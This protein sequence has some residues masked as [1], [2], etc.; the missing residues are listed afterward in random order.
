MLLII[1][2]IIDRDFIIPPGLNFPVQKCHS[3]VFQKRTRF[4][5]PEALSQN[6]ISCPDDLFY[7]CWLHPSSDQKA[8]N[9][10]K[11]IK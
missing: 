10:G 2:N 5:K 1:K 8:S 4:V 11:T 6:H 3:P 7:Q 9:H